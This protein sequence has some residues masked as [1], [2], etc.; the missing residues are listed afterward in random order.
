MTALGAVL[1]G[2]RSRRMGEPKTLVQLDGA[3]LLLRP[4]T[5]L[6]AV[7]GEVAVVCKPHTPL[8]PLPEGVAVWHES[9]PHRH[10]LV[11]VRAALRAAAGRPVVV[12]AGDM[13]FV[14]AATVSAL[15]AAPPAAAVVAR[16]GG[17]LHPLLARYGPEALARLE[18]A[19]PQEPAT[20]AVE[21]LE[22]ALLDVAE[23]VAFNVNTL[24][25]LRVARRSPGAAGHG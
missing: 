6:S 18:P 15:A 20:R 3:P 1:A 10:P 4:L 13:P 22:P 11:G 25:D 24:Q 23:R 14:D 5:V 7:L 17:R 12:V 19:D 8:P 2:G 21:R 9:D 16:A